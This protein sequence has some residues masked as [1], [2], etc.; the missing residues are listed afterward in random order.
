MDD[1]TYIPINDAYY[2]RAFVPVLIG[3]LLI[4]GCFAIIR[5]SP[6]ESLDSMQAFGQLGGSIQ[7]HAKQIF[8][9]K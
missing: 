2:R 3:I 7:K 5:A 9:S 4:V 6:G 1:T 8:A